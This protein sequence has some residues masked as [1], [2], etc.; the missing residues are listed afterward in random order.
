M[1]SRE[2]PRIYQVEQGIDLLD[3]GQPGYNLAESSYSFGIA[4]GV[5]NLVDLSVGRHQVVKFVDIENILQ[6]KFFQLDAIDGNYDQSPI[7]KTPCGFEPRTEQE[8]QMLD[9]GH[10][11]DSRESNIKG[12]AE[13]GFGS[14]VKFNI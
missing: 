3:K 5:D 14:Y 10:C 6:F 4:T 12:D 9:F 7:P 11:I 1:L 13:F 8:R 2:E